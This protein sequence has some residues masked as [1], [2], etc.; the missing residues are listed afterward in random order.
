[1]IEKLID[2][3]SDTKM[4]LKST[5]NANM[6]NVVGMSGYMCIVGDKQIELNSLSGDRMNTSSI[7]NYSFDDSILKA[8]TQS[9]NV[10]IFEVV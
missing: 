5:T 8:T 10:Y 9:G 6:Q 4:I 1:M 7:V 2:E 3:L